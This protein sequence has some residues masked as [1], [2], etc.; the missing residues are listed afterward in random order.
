M[1]A[2]SQKVTEMVNREMANNTRDMVAAP[3]MSNPCTLS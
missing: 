2:E 3:D 1:R